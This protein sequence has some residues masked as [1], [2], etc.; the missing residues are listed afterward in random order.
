M[1]HE[2]FG[3]TDPRS[4]PPALALALG[5][6]ARPKSVSLTGAHHTAANHPL[7]SKLQ[8]VPVYTVCA[9]TFHFSSSCKCGGFTSFLLFEVLTA[10][11]PCDVLGKRLVKLF[12]T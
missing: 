7:L 4:P 8:Y 12:S 3:P 1:S 11:P 9:K 2:H 5:L 6:K 10:H